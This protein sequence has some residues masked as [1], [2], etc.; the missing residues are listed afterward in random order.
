M[1]DDLMHTVRNFL[2]TWRERSYA[3]AISIGVTAFMPDHESPELELAKADV[4]C[5]MAKREGRNRVHVY[6]DDDMSLSRHHGEMHLVSAISQALSAGDFRLY[7]QPIIPLG[8]T[9]SVP[10]AGAQTTHYEILVRMLDEHG[11]L[12]TPASFIPAA[13]RYILMPAVD[14]WVIHQLFSTQAQGLR[15]W[16]RHHPGDFLYAVNISGTSVS[17]ASFLPYLKRQFELHEVPPST[18]CFELTET[19]A[20]R[21]VSQARGF[22]RT[23]GELGCSFA[24]DDFGS[25]LSSYAYLRELPVQYL[26]IDGGFVHNMHLD[27]VNYAL[28][29]SINQVAHV[30]GLKTIAE[31][32]ENDS[33]IAQLRA[34]SVDFVQGFAIGSPLPVVDAVAG[35]S[36]DRHDYRGS[37]VTHV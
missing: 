18:I 35:I 1:C 15:R 30:L 32:A 25:G 13:E 23:L 26:K 5:H 36:A 12:V 4:A 14:R 7:A 17:D 34:L 10:C 28:V 22:I 9:G 20:L 11:Q 16:H 27:P 19:A 6:N 3:V 31:W 21:S 24:L 8:S 33:I 37:D 29:A 2:Y